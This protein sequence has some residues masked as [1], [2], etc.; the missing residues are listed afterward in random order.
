M[1]S[2][3]DPRVHFAINLVLSAAFAA[4]ILWGLEFVGVGTLTLERFVLGTI[5]LMA[6]TYLVT[7]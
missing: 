7:R 4:F 6:V 1:A 2:R 5:V 3:G